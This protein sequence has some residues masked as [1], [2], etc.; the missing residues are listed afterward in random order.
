MRK[1]GDLYLL[2]PKPKNHVVLGIPNTK[3]RIIMARKRS[4]QEYDVHGDAGRIA[5]QLG[6]PRGRYDE[7]SSKFPS[8]RNQG[9]IVSR[10]KPIL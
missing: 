6:T 1:N 2:Y 3:S 5:T 7:Y 9:L 4:R 8:V 10:K